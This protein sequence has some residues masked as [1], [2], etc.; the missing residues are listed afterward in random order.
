MHPDC[1]ILHVNS[2]AESAAFYRALLGREPVEQSANFAMFM[3]ND[4]TMLGL[5]AVHDVQ[6]APTQRGGAAEIGVTVAT[7][8]EVDGAVAGWRAAGWPVLQ[9]PTPMDFGYTAVTADP[10]GHRV[11][12]FRP[13]QG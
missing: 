7:D 4:K 10:D 1:L 9:A 13:T 5:W 8:A 2:P 12:M 3:L 6:P 11:R